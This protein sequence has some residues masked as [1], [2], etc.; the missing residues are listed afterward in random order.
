MRR[1]TVHR[2]EPDHP[3][4]AALL[5]LLHHQPLVA[6]AELQSH[7]RFC[8]ACRARM[9]Y[10]S[11]RELEI[12][13]LLA[14]LDHPVPAQD[15]DVILGPPGGR[16]MRRGTLVGS[17][18]LVVAAAAAAATLPGSP[19]RQWVQARPTE[20]RA[21]AEPQVMTPPLAAASSSVSIAAPAELVVT[22][23]RPQSHGVVDV[24]IGPDGPAT[25]RSRGGAV[26]YRVGDGHITIDNRAPADAYEIRVPAALANLV[27]LMGDRVVFRKAGGAIAPTPGLDSGTRYRMSLDTSGGPS[28]NAR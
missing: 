3:P 23:L 12:G 11:C 18:G 15:L 17:I 27:I 8:E 4:E 9:L 24:T 20:A 26:S 2:T 16:G 21:A 13:E 14:E 6:R 28:G 5:T 10:L 7:L 19:V 1:C 22:L 25:V